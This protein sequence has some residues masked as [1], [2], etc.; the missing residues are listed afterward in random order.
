MIGTRMTTTTLAVLPKVHTHGRTKR[1]EILG[2]PHDCITI[3]IPLTHLDGD[4]FILTDS[5]GASHHPEY[6]LDET[7]LVFTGWRVAH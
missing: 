1:V 5:I 3:A 2:G 7:W 4:V 6:E